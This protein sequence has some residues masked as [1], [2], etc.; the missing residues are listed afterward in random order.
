[1]G[2]IGAAQCSAGARDAVEL[3]RVFCTST[4]ALKRGY[5]VCYDRDNTTA[6]NAAGTAIAATSESWGRHRYVDQPSTSNLQWFAGFIDKDYDANANGQFINIVVPTGNIT[7]VW[8]DVNC[9]INSS[10]LCLEPGA[11]TLGSGTGPVVAIAAQ[12]VDRSSTAGICNAVAYPVAG[13]DLSLEYGADA[14]DQPSRSIWSKFPS[15][16]DFVRDPSL[17]IWYDS[18]YGS[19]AT[20]YLD[21]NSTGASL[22]GG[23]VVLG[24]TADNEEATFMGTNGGFNINTGGTRL[25]F[26]ARV[27]A[28]SDS[29]PTGW[30]VGLSSI[31]PG[32]ADFLLDAGAVPNTAADFVGFN[33]PEV[34]PDGID[35]VYQASGQSLNVHDA[36]AHTAVADTYVNLGFLFDG[37]DCTVYVNG[38]AL[39]ATSEPI[40]AADI[41]GADFPTG[42][43]L[44]PAASNKAGG[45]PDITLTVAWMRA[46]QL[47]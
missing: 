37:T 33:V 27:K 1:M 42:T 12:T 36:N 4:D 5:P 32:A 14:G 2:L 10:R 18:R 30:A 16:A 9:T 8:T 25:A 21:T 44:R 47:A 28:S 3:K 23:G 19:S 45:T 40:L 20:L 46:I 35:V 34:D 41:A 17:G 11:W 43:A 6:T 24:T 15:V 13:G 31:A 38:T 22:A 29:D 7:D 26:E 39:S